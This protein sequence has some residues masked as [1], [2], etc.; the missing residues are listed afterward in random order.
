MLR[1]F[2]ML[3]PTTLVLVF[4]VIL[5]GGVVRT[6][7]SGM[8]CPDWPKCFGRYIPPTDLSQLPP[9]YK[10][11]FAVQGKEIADFDVFK[12]WTEYI[13]RLLGA[14]LGVVVIGLMISSAATLKRTKQVFSAAVLM[15]LMT[16]FVGWL[17]SVVV[18]SDLQPVKIT[19]HMLSAL[20]IVA[21]GTFI[22]ERNEQMRLVEE[23][24]ASDSSLVQLAGSLKPWLIAAVV[25]SVVQVVLGTQVREQIDDIA[26]MLGEAERH[27]WVDFLSVLFP[28]HRSF[29]IVVVLISGYVFYG[30]LQAKHESSALYQRMR[31]GSLVMMSALLA[32]IGLG[33]TL[34][35]FSFPAFAQ[36]LHL[37][38]ACVMVAA[39]ASLLLQVMFISQAYRVTD[40][41]APKTASDAIASKQL[42]SK[43]NHASLTDAP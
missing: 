19:L 26:K 30:I 39:Q 9:D 20:A 5:A 31:I 42:H 12:T 32:E 10:T 21:I 33:V 6:T 29:S 24:E 17:G 25:I 28:V 3:L 2:R 13:N 38:L 8:G 37:L 40:T 11:R 14:L 23:R 4:L 16:G 22:L 7:G 1:F 43:T 18:A 34:S 15:V 41:T 36:P 35:Y 27:R